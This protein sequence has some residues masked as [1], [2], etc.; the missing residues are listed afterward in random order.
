MD[1]ALMRPGRTDRILFVD[2]PD[3]TARASIFK[4]I[5]K[6]EDVAPD[7]DY[8]KLA[9]LTEGYSGAD[10]RAICG[11]ASELALDAEESQGKEFSINNA[12]LERG[13]SETPRS[14]SDELR[15]TYTAAA[16]KWART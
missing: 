11:R 9:N 10:I 13:V 4:V 8:A 5:L 12:F 16:E 1:P 15:Q 14:V 7:I 2:L 6:V 3:S